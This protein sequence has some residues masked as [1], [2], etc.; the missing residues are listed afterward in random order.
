MS[1]SL[2]GS[3]SRSTDPAKHG[4][5]DRATLIYVLIHQPGYQKSSKETNVV[6]IKNYVTLSHG[7]RCI[8]AKHAGQRILTHMFCSNARLPTAMV[9]THASKVQGHSTAAW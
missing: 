9:V 4:V 8:G 2:S 6:I 5:T 1:R 7:Q 3:A